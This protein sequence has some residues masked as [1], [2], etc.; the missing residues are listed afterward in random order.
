MKEYEEIARKLKLRRAELELRLHKI[1]Q[2]IRRPYARNSEEQALEQEEEDVLETLDERI[3]AELKQIA[4]ALSRIER[5]EYG[6][7]V[8]CDGEIPIE[9]LE[10]LPYTDRCTACAAEG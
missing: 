4:D 1:E 8:V 10:A 6:I 3:L 5:K 7:C 2:D 9:R